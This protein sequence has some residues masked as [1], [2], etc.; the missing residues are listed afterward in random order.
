[1]SLKLKVAPVT[2]PRPFATYYYGIRAADAQ[3]SRIG[4]ATTLQTA[5]RAA[6]WNIVQRKYHSAVI[7]DEA[8]IVVARIMRNRNQITAIGV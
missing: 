1:M 3:W 7:H 4:R 2:H 5:S 6:F 8:G